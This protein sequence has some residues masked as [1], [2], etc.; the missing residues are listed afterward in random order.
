MDSRGSPGAG[1]LR[2]GKRTSTS[3]STASNK[4]RQSSLSEAAP[5]SP[6]VFTSFPNFTPPPSASPKRRRS[7]KDTSKLGSNVEDLQT[8]R[9]NR[10]P[11]GEDSFNVPTIKKAPG[12]SGSSQGQKSTSSFAGKTLKGA[13]NLHKSILASLTFSSA[14][15]QLP[16]DGV[17]DDPDWDASDPLA[18]ATDEQIQRVIDRN[19]GAVSLLRQYSEDLAEANTRVAQE[20]N[21]KLEVIERNRRLRDESDQMKL[22]LEDMQRKYKNVQNLLKRFVRPDQPGQIQIVDSPNGH[23]VL[24]STTGEMIEATKPLRKS[25]NPSTDTSSSTAASPT[26]ESPSKPVEAATSLKQSASQKRT[27]KDNRSSRVSISMRPESL[28]TRPESLE[29]TAPM[30]AEQLPPALRLDNPFSNIA[31]VDRLGFYFTAS[32]ETRQNEALVYKPGD[33]SETSS[34]NSYEIDTDDLDGKTIRSQDDTSSFKA[35]VNGSTD[36]E[37]LC[38]APSGPA[39]RFVSGPDKGVRMFVDVSMP[40]TPSEGITMS[41]I[42]AAQSAATVAQASASGTMVT[43]TQDSH[44]S[45]N[46]LGTLLDKFNEVFDSQQTTRMSEWTAFHNHLRANIP[47]TLSRASSDYSTANVARLCSKGTVSAET[48]K[49]F[50]NLILSGIPVAVRR[51]VWMERTGANALSEPGLYNTLVANASIPSITSNEITADIDRTL[52]NN[53]F[54]RTGAGKAKL[55]DILTAYAQHN[56]TIGY[57]QGLNIISANLLLML[58]SAEDAFWLLVAVIENILPFEYYHHDGNISGQSLDIDGKVLTS[59]VV[60]HLG[61]ALH[62]H[63]HIHGVDLSMFTPG[64]FI[65]AFAACLSGEPLYR[66][67]DV[68]FGFCDGRYMFCFALALLKINRRGLLKCESAEELML[69]LGGRMTNAA[70]GLDILVKEGVRMGSIVTTEDLKKRRKQF[71]ELQ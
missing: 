30:D 34:L 51:E 40:I 58:P 39:L 67:W 46:A 43:P 35:T 13:A 26:K 16:Q 4:S 20:R 66:I 61:A 41:S 27:S 14:A 28:S 5:A 52:G 25:F 6:K 21:G 29:L 44:S 15:P 69:Y 11:S 17:F 57:S 18:E 55:E 2:G 19:G 48:L 68:L 1:S 59:Y 71:G 8:G 49:K 53:I 24:D 65:S 56:P 12:A 38:Y 42:E 63:L 54:F 31:P 32:R 23:F 10:R 45:A 50:N 37:L 62:K 33:T 22:Q 47:K 70:V 60:D 7:S 64:W 9:Q 3:S 36:G